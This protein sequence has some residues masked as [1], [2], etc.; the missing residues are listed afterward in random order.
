[1]KTIGKALSN[2][3]YLRAENDRGYRSIPKIMYV[4]NHAMDDGTIR[5][6]VVVEEN[7]EYT[8]Y[9]THHLHQGETPQE[10]KDR[11]EVNYVKKEDCKAYTVRYE[12]IYRKMAEVSNQMKFFKDCVSNGK[13][14]ELWTLEKDIDLHL[15]D[16]HLADY[17]IR[18]WL[19]KNKSQMMHIPL[20]KA[21]FDIEVDIYGFEGFPEPEAA[22]CAVSLISY[23]YE[24]TMTLH[25][26]ILRNP[27]NHSQTEF[28]EA[29]EEHK[30]EYVQILLEEFN[31][32][33]GKANY[34]KL[35]DIRFHIYDDEATLIAKFFAL[36]KRDKPD[37][38]GAWNA[39]FDM[40]TLMNRLL[41]EKENV[42][43]IMC[44]QDFP[45]RQVDI[46]PDTFNTD[47]SKRKSVFDVTGYTQFIC[48]LENFA[49]IRATMGKRESYALD[50]I[51]FEEI[52]ESK[53]EYEGDIQDAMYIDFEGFL[54][55]SLYD[56][57]RLY[58]LEE[59][60][61]DIDL[62]YNMGLMTATRFSKVMTKTTSIRNFAA[63]LLE[64]EGYILSNNHNKQ[65][66]HGE[67]K[68]FRGAF[69][70]LPS[71]MVPVG[72]KLNGQ[73][74]T[75]V[76]ENVIDEDL[77]SLYP[78]IILAFNIDA[79]TMIGKIMCKERPELD[80]EIPTMLAEADPVKIG[81]EL[82]GLPNVSDILSDLEHYVT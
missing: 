61:K 69:V 48:L 63:M 65:K 7:P 80:D 31:T 57:F 29:F 74:S 51:L 32:N 9:S 21:F 42:T 72:I 27:N 73:R 53:F 77:A 28:L 16:I 76:Y 17:K 54:K 22:P 18:E 66:D 75:K 62:L 2:V 40:P 81:K 60:N 71:K 68:K 24:P 20:A 44:H 12:D 43:R 25:S 55:Y 35:K 1:M 58:Q 14:R 11:S 6:E 26:F 8:F 47:W 59:K 19:D 70:A 41:K 5:K 36:V 15:T 67:K 34:K 33:N 4:E 82:L 52:G 30:E 49:S 23:M 50:A 78:S 37:F 56:S 45:Y 10:K 46:R 79:D 38:C 3:I 64:K 13:Y 39:S